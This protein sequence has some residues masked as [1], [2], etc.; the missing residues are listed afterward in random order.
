MDHRAF[1]IG[2]IFTIVS[3]IAT[4]V[5]RAI[6]RFLKW[7]F[8]VEQSSCEDAEND[9]CDGAREAWKKFSLLDS[10]NVR[11]SRAE[12]LSSAEL[13]MRRLMMWSTRGKGENIKRGLMPIVARQPGRLDYMSSRF[14]AEIHE[15]FVERLDAG[16]LDSE[17]KKQILLDIYLEELLEQYPEWENLQACLVAGA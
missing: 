11:E 12:P 8:V 3:D 13:S 4:N 17:E 10:Q 5:N 6:A 14:V 16:E 1:S 9:A 2:A 7:S 15:D